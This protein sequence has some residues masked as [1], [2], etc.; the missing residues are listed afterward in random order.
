MGVLAPRQS[1]LRMLAALSVAA[2]VAS[3]MPGPNGRRYVGRFGTFGPA[4]ALRRSGCFTLTASID[5]GADE[6]RTEDELVAV[7]RRVA[8][9][10]TPSDLVESTASRRATSLLRSLDSPWDA[11]ISFGAMEL[12]HGGAQRVFEYAEIL[13]SV[14]VGDVADAAQA[15]LDCPRT[16]VVTNFHGQ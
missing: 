3:A 1:G 7:I 2:D 8:D 6:E 11:P 13:R 15:L 4:I 16:V 10:A 9:G 14:S 5:L 12:N